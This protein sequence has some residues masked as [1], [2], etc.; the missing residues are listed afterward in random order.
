MYTLGGRAEYTNEIIEVDG[1]VMFRTTCEEDL[2]N[3]LTQVTC[4]GI[5]CDIIRRVNDVTNARNRDKI[6]ISGPQM[7]GI[8]EYPVMQLLQDMPGASELENYRYK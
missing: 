1:K 5:W 7:F 4:S 3:P 6:S 8:A 2:E